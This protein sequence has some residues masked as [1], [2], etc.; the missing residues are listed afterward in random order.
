[1]MVFSLIT[2]YNCFALARSKANPIKDSDRK[3]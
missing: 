1:M 3:R 2:N